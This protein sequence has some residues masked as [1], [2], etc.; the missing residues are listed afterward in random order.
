[1]IATNSSP[2][3]AAGIP[4]E[5]LCADSGDGGFFAGKEWIW[6]PE[7]FRLPATLA[8]ELDWMGRLLP[9]FA[10]ACD[11]LY[12]QSAEGR[13][14]A[15]IAH[16]LDL[17]KPAE[18]VA[19]GRSKAFRGQTA[20]VI[21][22]DLVITAEGFAIC[23]LDQ[24]PGGI[25]LTAWLNETYDRGGFE[26]LGG[27]EGMLQGFSSILSGGRILVSEEAATYRPEMEW[28]SARLN[29]RSM[30]SGSG[31]RWSV[32]DC[33]IP[34]TVEGGGG[35]ELSGNF[36]RFFELFDLANVP[37]AEGL[38]RSVMAGEATVTPPPKAQLE[39]K[40]WM[41]LLWMHPLR[42]FWIRQLGESGFR[43]LKQWIPR[44][45]V[46]D[47]GPLPPAAVHPGLE[48]QD[49]KELA[50]FSQRERELIVKVSGFDERAWGA[51]GV[52]LGSDLSREEW[53][54]VIGDALREF[55]EH[56]RILQ[57]YRRPILSEQTFYKPDGA[58]ETM[59]GRVRISPYFF[60]ADDG[61]AMLGGALATV[62]PADKKILH[63]MRDA[64][65]VPVI[66]DR[67]NSGDR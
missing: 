21:R 64:V 51:R 13:Q 26:V 57:V 5:I 33:V 49:W 44:T 54:S 17:G 63:G 12:R 38:F 40:L 2:S 31:E 18:L 24:I 58:K 62:C 65:M 20:R 30:A 56:P 66:A 50:A 19:L 10:T 15:W 3:P 36:Y 37:C 53:G 41:A 11:L 52:A 48:I 67:Q 28:L 16:L 6:A 14:P 39:E 46:L 43:A 23:E 4:L 22:P 34:D 7:P 35:M 59:S 8:A 60:V 27:G 45:W 32:S 25:G 47:P 9:K 1:M 42:E 55:S 61:R 29:V